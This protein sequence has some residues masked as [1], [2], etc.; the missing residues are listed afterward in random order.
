MLAFVLKTGTGALSMKD[1][2]I[3]PGADECPDKE[4]LQSDAFPKEAKSMEE[5]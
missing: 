3:N 4:E 1:A 2:D 5:K